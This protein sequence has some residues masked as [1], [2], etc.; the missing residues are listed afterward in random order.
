[1]KFFDASSPEV[2]V[3]YNAVFS[4]IKNSNDDNKEDKFN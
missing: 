1:M 3:F 2:E 4:N